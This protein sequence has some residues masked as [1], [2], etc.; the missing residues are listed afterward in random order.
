[1]EVAALG[2]AFEAFVGVV[3]EHP[4]VVVLGA[5]ARV[6]LHR[7]RCNIQQHPESVAGITMWVH[8]QLHKMER[9]HMT[10]FTSYL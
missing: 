4:V 9:L 1:M 5:I 6:W 10:F 3:E 7:R 8:S 2:E